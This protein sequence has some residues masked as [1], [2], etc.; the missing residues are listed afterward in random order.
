MADCSTV[1][2]GSKFSIITVGCVCLCSIYAFGNSGT[3]VHLFNR[4]TCVTEMKFFGGQCQ[5]IQLCGCVGLTNCVWL[6]HDLGSSTSSSSSSSL[7]RSRRGPSNITHLSHGR[8]SAWRPTRSSVS[9]SKNLGS[10]TDSSALWPTYRGS[11]AHRL[12]HFFELKFSCNSKNRRFSLKFRNCFRKSVPRYSRQILSLV[13]LGAPRITHSKIW[14]PAL[15]FFWK[16]GKNFFGGLEPKFVASLHHH[17]HGR[18]HA[19]RGLQSDGW[20]RFV[21][22]LG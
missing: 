21:A 3:Y 6:L 9:C 17:V 1:W 18:Q 15:R 10:W 22:G 4:N 7:S 5:Y 12:N 8:L 19:S 13:G 11:T 14:T 16:L 20:N 2:A